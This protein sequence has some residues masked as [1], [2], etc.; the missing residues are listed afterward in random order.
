M[1][2]IADSFP[3]WITLSPGIHRVMTDRII[4]LLLVL[5][6]LSWAASAQ[7]V[8]WSESYQ[9]FVAP[10][11]E[12]RQHWTDFLTQLKDKKF[13]SVTL[14]GSFDPTGVSLNDPTGATQLAALLASGTPGTI[15]SG[16][17]AWTVT[18]CDV[19]NGVVATALSVDGNEM[20]CDCDDTYALRPHSTNG[21]W[22]GVNSPSVGSC[23]ATSQSMKLEFG[24]GVTIVA[25]GATS[26][27]RGGNVVLTAQSVIC[28]APLTYAWSNG[29]TTES[30]TVTEAGTYSV[31]VSDENGCKATSSPITVNYAE[32]SVNAGTDALYCDQPVQLNAVGVS[33]GGKETTTMNKICLFDDPTRGTG[34]CN[35]S[36]SDDICNEGMKEMLETTEF[37]TTTAIAN[38]VEIRYV[39]Y[40]TAWYSASVN[41]KLNGHTLKSFTDANPSGNCTIAPTVFSFSDG[42]FKPYWNESGNNTLTIEVIG[43]T[44]FYIAG[45]SVELVTSDVTYAWTPADGLNSATIASPLAVP[46]VSTTYTVTYT[47]A[48]GCQATDQVSVKVQ[49]DEAP[50]AACKPLEVSI[51]EGCEATVLARDF[52][53]GSNSPTGLPLTYAISPAGPFPIGTTEVL[54]TVTDSNLNTASCTTTIT[55]KDTA[56][57]VITAEP[58]ITIPTDPGLCTAVLVLPAVSDNC[59]VPS[60]VS[61]QLNNVLPVG[62]TMVTWTATDLNGNQQT[63]TQIVT[64]QNAAPVINAVVASES[65]VVLGAATL[66]T[67]DYTDN[68]ISDATINWGD[69]S[70]S[71]VISAPLSVFEATHTYD[72]PGTYAVTVTLTDIC[73]ASAS[74]VYE[75]I[76]VLSPRAGW[77]KGGGWFESPAGAHRKDQTATGRANFAFDVQYT[78]NSSGPAGSLSFTFKSADLKFKSTAFNQLL[79]NGETARLTGTGIVDGKGGYGILIS[80][81]DDDTKIAREGKGRPPMIKSDRLRVKIWDREGIVIYDTQVGEADDAVATTHI[82]VGSVEVGT[83]SSSFSAT[84]QETLASSFGEEST[85]VYPNPFSDLINVQFNSES[86]KDLAVQLMDGTG[87]VL[88]TGVYPVSSNGN[89]ML[90]IPANLKAGI[91][92]LS[93]RQGQRLELLNVIRN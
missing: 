67:I 27:C 41:L 42:Q 88:A 74:V 33:E 84:S 47:D 20:A 17:H 58:E 75:S 49:C 93:I 61:D 50:I 11:A 82:G 69:A 77:A 21:D 81:V 35:Y 34:N 5:C 10:T 68:N 44:K 43:S 7:S 38:P 72:A 63:T 64:V 73:G 45:L 56:L 36:S 66:L 52:D 59:G 71:T 70:Q 87:R 25:E 30:I 14:S 83:S 92:V 23:Q 60:I 80:M 9:Q 8:T 6:S 37:T 29:A 54:F 65:S 28:S 57:P 16:G 13:A 31:T 53:N 79:V 15:Y 48:N 32:V 18:R 24:S 12:Q 46:A 22:G 1:K 62:T 91:Y 55:V 90:D 78:E 40:Y 26:I 85:S 86:T 4:L 19:G 39:V 89:Y 51:T 76:T 2:P 3:T